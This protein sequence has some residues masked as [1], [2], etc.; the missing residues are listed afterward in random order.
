MTDEVG[1][2]RKETYSVAGETTLVSQSSD[3]DLATALEPDSLDQS[4]EADH[5]V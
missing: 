5:N 3:D 2:R 4:W 1:K